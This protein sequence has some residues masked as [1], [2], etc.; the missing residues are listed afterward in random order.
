MQLCDVAEEY[1]SGAP[2][3]CPALEWTGDR[4]LCGLVTRPSYHLKINFNGDKVLTP[5]FLQA[6]AAGQGC[7]CPDEE[8]T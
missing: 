1:W 8:G 3:P 5:L 4:F 6:I 7:G 2:L